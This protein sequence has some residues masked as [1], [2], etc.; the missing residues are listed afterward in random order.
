MSRFFHTDPIV[1]VFMKICLKMLGKYTKILQ[2]FLNDL[3]V[4]HTYD[5]NSIL[6][7]TEELIWVKH[8][9]IT[10][11]PIINK[12]VP[13]SYF[14]SKLISEVC[15]RDLHEASDWPDMYNLYPTPFTDWE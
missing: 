1:F 15:W 7:K 2:D 12:I 13:V 6:P 3:I 9:L 5:H 14:E 8:A 4:L 11:H 10:L